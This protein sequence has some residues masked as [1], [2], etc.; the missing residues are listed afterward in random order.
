MKKQVF[1]ATFFQEMLIFFNI[2]AIQNIKKQYNWVVINSN[3]Y[4][5]GGSVKG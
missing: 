2:N 4:G 5:G 1:L 3:V